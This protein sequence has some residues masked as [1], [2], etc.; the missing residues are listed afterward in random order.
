MAPSVIPQ[1]TSTSLATLFGEY[2]TPWLMIDSHQI[3]TPGSVRPPFS[4]LQSRSYLTP[5][6]PIRYLSY[7]MRPKPIA[8]VDSDEAA[9]PSSSDVPAR[10]H[11]ERIQGALAN[12]T[13]MPDF[14]SMF[15]GGGSSSKSEPKTSKFPEKTFKA[16]D[17]KLRLIFMGKDP[18]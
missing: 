10:G 6:L 13:K 5:F 11:R 1:C 9:D 7:L 14:T 12:A 2:S 18:K 17:D 15:M 4:N 16:L 8:P 3:C